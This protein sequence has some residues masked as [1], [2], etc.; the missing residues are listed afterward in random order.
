MSDEPQPRSVPNGPDGGPADGPVMPARRSLMLGAAGAAAVMSIRPAFAQTNASILT[1]EIPVPDA[2]RRSSY[3]AA[4]GTLVPSGTAGAVP[5]AT[6][7]FKGE[8]VRRALA[9]GQ[10]PAT[11]YE[12][13]RAYL[14]YIRNLHSGT[15]GYTCFVS[16]QMPRG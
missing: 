15:S 6:Q 14:A 12:R 5:P 3:V 2:A 10:L 4:D 16:L 9:G 7:P 11:D 1:C 8:D 13:N